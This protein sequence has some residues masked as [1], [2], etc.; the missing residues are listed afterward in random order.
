MSVAFT[1]EESAE[2]A[3][4]TLL[5]DRPISPHPNLVTEAGLQALQ[6]QLQQ[7][8]EA[9]EAAQAIED[10]NEKR[11]Q[12][13]VPLRDARYLTERLRTAQLIP[14]PTSTE[15]VAFGSTVTF[16][17]TDGRVQ[18]YRIV[19]ED[20]ADPKAGTISFVAPVARSLMGKA[21]GDVVG[22]GAQEI[23]ILSIA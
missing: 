6:T 20:E 7:A 16:S 3:S 13:A 10:V 14:D 12:S 5:P 23:E 8:R 9:Y 4:E 22:T 15:T 19:G 18:T 11:R 1:K 17:R 21:V 2:T